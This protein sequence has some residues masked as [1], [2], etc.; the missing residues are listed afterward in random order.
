MNVDKLVPTPSRN[1][2]FRRNRERFISAGS[3]CYVLTNFSQEVMY[4][5]LAK[6]IR[7]RFTQHLD[8]PHKIAVTKMGKAI[9]FFW[10]ETP[11][12]N[13]VERTWMNIHV[14]NE[15]ILPILNGVYS[16]TFT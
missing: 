9:F 4:V 15:G 10:L 14:L 16:P 1:E 3:G 11:D 6:N 2:V 12:T 8:S 5:G 7:K 13:K